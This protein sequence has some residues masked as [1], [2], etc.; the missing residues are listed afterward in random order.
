M[1]CTTGI[2]IPGRCIRLISGLACGPAM[3]FPVHEERFLGY[4]VLS[5]KENGFWQ[6]SRRKVRACK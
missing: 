5:W 1:D 4:S 2:F 6:A 3:A